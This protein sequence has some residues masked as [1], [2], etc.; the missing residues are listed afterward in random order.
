MDNGTSS[1]NRRIG[2]TAHNLRADQNLSLDAL[3]TKSGVSRSMISLIERGQAS[4]TAVVLERLAF[5]LGVPLARLFD[6][7]AADRDC[8]GPLARLEEQPQWRDPGSGY[9]RRNVSPAGWPSPIQ[10]VE[11]EF[12]PGARVA[13]ETGSREPHVHQQVWV[14]AGQI[15]LTLGDADYR[16]RTGDCLAM[17]LEQPIVYW[18]PT[19]ETARYV[20]VISAE[21]LPSRRTP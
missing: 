19:S 10:I 20:V 16:L 13:Y 7:P 3:A 1:I 5:G 2:E 12:P 6:V 17:L 18:N 8:P 21:V 9:V 14:L 11:V 15:H 4:P